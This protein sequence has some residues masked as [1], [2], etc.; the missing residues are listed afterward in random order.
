ML[1]DDELDDDEFELNLQRALKEREENKKRAENYP[2]SDKQLESSWVYPID[3]TREIRQYQYEISQASLL[4]NTLVVV[5]TGLGKTFIASVV[6]YNYYRWF[7]TGKIIF[8]LPIV[9]LVSQQYEA[10][11]EF[12]Q[13]RKQDV[14]I[15]TGQTTK[16]KA[17]GAIW[18]K[19]RVFFCTASIVVNDIRDKILPADQVVLLVVDE[20]H[21]ATREHDY[22]QIVRGL[23]QNT[24]HYRIL[25]L[26]ATPG[27]DMTVVYQVMKNLQIAHVEARSEEDLRKY[28]HFKE[29]LIREVVLTEPIIELKKLFFQLIQPIIFQLQKCGAYYETDLEKISFNSLFAAHK[30]FIGSRGGGADRNFGVG[31]GAFSVAIK[32]YHAYDDLITQ[33]LSVFLESLQNI[34]ETQTKEPK[35][36]RF[37]QNLL[38]A[39]AFHTMVHN[40]RRYLNAGHLHPKMV[41]LGKTIQEHFAKTDKTR[42]IIFV[43][44][45]STVASIVRYLSKFSPKV[46]AMEFVGQNK[47]KNNMGLTGKEQKEVIQKFVKGSYNTLVSTSVGEEGLD[48]GEV[49]LIICYDSVTSPTRLIQRIGRTGRKRDGKAVMI[50]TEG[51]EAAAFTRAQEKSLALFEKL[52]SL[53]TSKEPIF[54]KDNPRMLSEDVVPECVQV[55]MSTVDPLNTSIASPVKKRNRK[56]PLITT[57]ERRYLNGNYGSFKPISGAYFNILEKSIGDHTNML[58]PTRDI[59]HPDIL[60]LLVTMSQKCTDYTYDWDSHETS[61][62][63]I[64]SR[65]RQIVFDKA[66]IREQA[67]QE[68]DE[69]SAPILELTAEDGM[70][71]DPDDTVLI[72]N[73]H[74]PGQMT[75]PENDDVVAND[76]FILPE[77]ELGEDQSKGLPGRDG[78]ETNNNFAGN[79]WNG[80][81]EGFGGPDDFPFN[82]NN[83]QWDVVTEEKDQRRTSD[84]HSPVLLGSPVH[85]PIEK[86]PIEKVSS[87]LPA[88]AIID[89][90]VFLEVEQPVEEETIPEEL[91]EDQKFKDLNALMSTV[92]EGLIKPVYVFRQDI[93]E[94]LKRKR[95]TVRKYTTVPVAN[96]PTTTSTAPP[97]TFAK[98]SFPS[99]KS[100]ILLESEE[101]E[102]ADEESSEDDLSQQVTSS[103]DTN[104]RKRKRASRLTYLDEEA[105]DDEV[106]D[107]SDHEDINASSEISSE[108]YMPGTATQ[109]FV[110]YSEYDQSLTMYRRPLHSPTKDTPPVK[111]K[112]TL[113]RLRK[114]NEL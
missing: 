7:P 6:M 62:T 24:N 9:A 109:N 28:S 57:M 113:K 65:S 85:E 90:P 63:Q 45:K 78:Y 53:P 11:L 41:E 40:T 74:Y 13:F 48:I 89:P 67:I 25:A 30:S 34:H 52:K 114:N 20:A 84:N 107:T 51:R 68:L 70:D 10:C 92:F 8:V 14:A 80:D 60:K 66:V 15:M 97:S 112:R 87:P 111:K 105:D 1:D 17:R 29:I 32:F 50:L 4:K 16:P 79:D 33:D 38:N 100:S 58:T 42:V 49:D 31:V 5:P 86:P 94:I 73:D 82:D 26:S 91:F 19:K 59:P 54:Y 18:Q 2:K 55:D 96:T 35:K 71:V 56:Q 102:E 44:Q 27:K 69:E 83:N 22:C 76:A 81:N 108:D 104:R 37:L 3:P 23:S 106:S 98:S 93:P 99:A 95:S 21:K 75:G 64:Y 43:S 101:D 39:P 61:R 110:T 88:P 77:V 46:K 12:V 47:G 36:N 72:V 103:S